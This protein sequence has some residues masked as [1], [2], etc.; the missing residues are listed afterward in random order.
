MIRTC[1]DVTAGPSRRI[2]RLSHARPLI[3]VRGVLRRTLPPLPLDTGR[4]G[5]EREGGISPSPIGGGRRRTTSLREEK[6]KEAFFFRSRHFTAVEDDGDVDGADV[7]GPEPQLDQHHAAAPEPILL[8][9]ALPGTGRSLLHRLLGRAGRLAASEPG[10]D[11]A[12]LPRR[13]V[14]QHLLAGRRLPARLHGRRRALRLAVLEA[15]AERRGAAGGRDPAED[16]RPPDREAPDGVHRNDKSPQ[17][18]QQL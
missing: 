18:L 17:Q 10:G 16:R 3:D 13:P 14:Q 2:H 12:A 15:A 7:N 1:G 11:R 5:R 4:V 8:P 6:K 9:G